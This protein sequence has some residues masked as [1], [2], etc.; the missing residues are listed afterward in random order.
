MKYIVY[1]KKACPNCDLTKQLLEQKGIDFEYI[2][3][4]EDISVEDLTTTL[5]A[6]K[7]I[8]RSFPQIIKSFK[9]GNGECDEYVGGLQDMI[10]ILKEMR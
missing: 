2:S 6:F 5:G 8:P 7:V 9:V 4:P 3:A 1:G 10:A